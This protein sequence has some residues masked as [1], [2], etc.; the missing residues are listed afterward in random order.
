[1]F[2]TIYFL[3]I[4]NIILKQFN[5]IWKFDECFKEVNSASTVKFDRNCLQS[6]FTLYFFHRVFYI[7][8][9]STELLSNGKEISCMF[10]QNG[11]KRCHCQH[12]VN[13]MFQI[14]CFNLTQDCWLSSFASEYVKMLGP[15]A[16]KWRFTSSPTF[17]DCL[18]NWFNILFKTAEICMENSMK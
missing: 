17:P 7:P 8:I 5:L 6:I 14:N 15:P 3:R 16:K 11:Q 4:S 9:T 2:Q 13:T 10:L 1:M 18:L 12:Q